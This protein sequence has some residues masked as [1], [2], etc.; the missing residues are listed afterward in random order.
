[1]PNRSGVTI[2]DVAARAGVSHQTVSRVINGSEQVAPETRARVEAAIA[3]LD[4][5]PNAIAR[6]MAKGH[7]RTL[8]CISPN[9]TDYTFASI[10]EGAETEARQHGYFLISASAPD[11]TAFSILIEELI[12][13]RRTDGL[14]VINPYA[15]GRRQF[16]PQGV[17]TVF[18]G[19]QSRL[20]AVSSVTLD[21][22]GAACMA[23]QHLLKLGHRRIAHITGVLEEECSQERQA[24]YEASLAASGIDVRPELVIEGDWSA[25]SGYQTTRQL[26]DSGVEFTALFAQNDRMAVGAIRA[27]REAGRAVPEDVSVIGLDDMPLTSYFDP[28]LTTLRQDM[29]GMGREAA[30]LLIRAI[31]QPGSPRQNLHISAD[32]VIRRST[33]QLV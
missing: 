28:P 6:F 19:S 8:A 23:V 5:R 13:S 7:S 24:G 14:F 33:N 18:I 1:M 4:Y 31:E 29:F 3:E 21:D 25:T 26:I 9:L 17:P 2:R 30:R 32:L 12:Q 11:D 15:D 27:L 10:I 22:R 20:P 16:L